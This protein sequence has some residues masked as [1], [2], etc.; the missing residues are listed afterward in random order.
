[1]AQRI[2]RTANVS[3][4]GAA[5]EI[6]H[7]YS[8]IQSLKL[9][10]ESLDM[11]TL[12]RSIALSMRRGQLTILEDLFAARDFGKSISLVDSTPIPGRIL[13]LESTQGGPGRLFFITAGAAQTGPYIETNAGSP[14][15]TLSAAGIWTDGCGARGKCDRRPVATRRLWQGINTLKIERWRSRCNG[16]ERH[17][18]PTRE[19]LRRAFGLQ[20]V[21]GYDL[22]SLA[23]RAIQDLREEVN[24][25]KREIRRLKCRKLKE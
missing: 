15:A 12:I 3:D 24:S 23:L 14:G 7:L 11:A 10:P 13:R 25:L 17:I 2:G 18:G 19:N 22:G 20:E 4:P 9:G 21:S 8:L 6:D 16:H 5:L 1:V